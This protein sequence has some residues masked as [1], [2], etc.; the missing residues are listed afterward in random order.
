M[1]SFTVG[2]FAENPLL[3]EEA[4]KQLGKKNDAVDVTFY[5]GVFE[6][7][8]ISA[9]DPSGFPEKIQPLVFAANLSDYCVVIADAI[10]PRLGEIIVVLDL[11][12]RKNGVLVSQ[13]IDFAPFV[14]G[15]SLENWKV[16]PTFD[17]A[18]MEVL[19][20][21]P[22]EAE[23][24]K[25]PKGIIDHAFEVKGVGTIL[26]GVLKRGEISVHDKLK[27][28][29]PALPI[30]VRSIQMHD[31]DVKKTGLNDR[32]GLCI[33]GLESKD[34]ERGFVAA[35]EM[36]ASKKISIAAAPTKFLREPVQNN[37]VLHASC[38]FQMAP[39]KIVFE[40]TEL[41]AGETKAATLEFEREYAFD[42]EDSL[43]LCRLNS[44][45]LRV[46]AK[47]NGLKPA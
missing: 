23:V 47:G 6:G 17:E 45:T 19:G 14:K 4:C 25:S 29:P 1:A 9:L 28:F 20:F 22:P 34:V 7:K 43:L 44:R 31:A 36:N 46:V 35:T 16:F 11:L 39:C 30:E 26:L 10:S 33:R 5:S 18:K 42:S 3:R 8:I 41:K 27:L 21:N 40:G 38:G 32:F 2:V 37:E 24:G 12:G 15:T 13:T